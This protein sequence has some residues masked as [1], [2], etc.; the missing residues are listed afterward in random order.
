LPYARPG[1]LDTTLPVTGKTVLPGFEDTHLDILAISSIFV[2]NISFL[3]RA[4]TATSG[5]KSPLPGR[6]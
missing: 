3:L 5:F 6:R 1:W 4:F 2:T